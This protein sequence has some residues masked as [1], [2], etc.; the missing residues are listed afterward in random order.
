MSTIWPTAFTTDSAEKLSA[1]DNPYRLIRRQAELEIERKRL[2]RYVLNGIDS[3]TDWAD[4]VDAL[5]RLG[6]PVLTSWELQFVASLLRWKGNPTAKQRAALN[7]TIA[8]IK[9]WA[10]TR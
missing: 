1:G 10:A 2:A 5:Q 9:S 3:R 7:R 6:T 4:A 8:R